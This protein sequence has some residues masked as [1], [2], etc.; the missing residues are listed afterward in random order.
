MTMIFLKTIGTSKSRTG[1]VLLTLFVLLAVAIITTGYLYCLRYEQDY[2]DEMD[3]QLS[4]ISELK[5]GELVQWRKERIGDC[6]ILFK[7]GA[8]VALVRRF[9][10]KPTD[11]DAQRQLSDW[12]GKISLSGQYDRIWLLDAKTVTRLSVPAGQQPSALAT[13]RQASEVLRSG[14]VTF[15]DFYRNEHDQRVYLAVL[16]PILDECQANQ[17]LGVI[18]LR[19]DPK[20]YLYP[21]IKRWPTLSPTAETLLVRREGNEVVFLNDPRF[22]ANASLNFRAPLSRTT[23]PA[24]Q[25]ALGRQGIMEGL[26]YRGVPVVSFLRPVPYS[27][28]SLVARIDT[29]EVYA[30]MR[31]QLWQVVMLICFLLSGA[32]AGLGLVWRQQRVH[33][34]RTR[35]ESAEALREEQR[36]ARSVIDS[37]PGIFFLYAYPEHRLV[38]WNKQHETLLGYTT[39]EM[40]ERFALDWHLPETK[41]AVLQATE[42]VMREGSSSVESSLLA[43]D[44]HSIPFYLT[45]VKFEA[46]GRLYYMGI[47]IDITERKEAEKTIR[48]LNA[49]LE[50]R[51]IERT[52]QLEAANKELEAF[53]YSVSHDLRAPLRHVEGYVDM[54]AREAGGHLSESARHYMKTIT[55]ASREMGVLIDDLLAF[56]RMGR[57]EMVET[58]IDL[59]ALVREARRELD[60]DETERERNI[61]WTIGPLPAVQADPAMLKLALVNLLANAVKFTRPRNPA[62]IEIGS[63]GKKD[64]RIILFVR[65]NGVGFDPQYARNLYGIFQRLHRADEFEGT[66]IG[67]ANVRRII[68]RHGGN[69]WAE[70]KINEGATFYFT[71]KPSIET[72]PAN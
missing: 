31:K 35:A 63:A 7:N 69:T 57:A 1:L 41:D 27:P 5:V 51:V 8:F 11:A 19:I 65:D 40:R 42:E 47:G 56:S 39:E 4:A 45:G 24:V 33:Y 32:G 54:L 29:A 34:Y 52:A 15:Q 44:G 50:Q 48:N 38:L 22:Q 66:G 10:E 43:K 6:S 2:R 68:A 59:E 14:Q 9:F 26:D 20:T 36:F 16:V 3:R 55:D 21:F 70:S 71:L 62:Q 60:L 49:E 17:M 64:D 12:M 25:A 30:P 58:G 46:H 13:L 67:L 53:S 23:M 37:L 72:N 18:V 28:W 61:A